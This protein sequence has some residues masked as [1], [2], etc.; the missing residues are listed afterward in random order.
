MRQ[1][2]SLAIGVSDGRPSSRRHV[3]MAFDRRSSHRHG[4]PP[5]LWERLT[6]HREAY[7]TYFRAA[8]S[9]KAQEGDLVYH[10]HVGHLLLPGVSHV[11]RV[12]VVAP[13]EYRLQTVLREQQ[14]TWSE[15][16]AHIERM[17]R[18]R[19]RWVRFLFGVD[20]EDPHL[21]NVILHL[22]RMTLASA[23]ETV[24]RLVSRPEFQPTATS[25]QALQ[26]FGLASHVEAVLLQDPRTQNG[27]L[28]VLATEGNLLITGVVWSPESDYRESEAGGLRWKRP[29]WAREDSGDAWGI[30]RAAWL[31]RSF[32]T[33][34]GQGN[35]VPE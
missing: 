16:R 12:R 28:Q 26:D 25:R 6:G 11:L 10:G 5:S 14:C 23:C 18:E 9:A 8:L 15:A 4:D 7:I 30:L 27:R 35:D 33:R 22:D 29:L 31:F 34:R 19:A 20:W 1:R 32:S 21:Y 17:D 2:T 13:L 3:R 24:C